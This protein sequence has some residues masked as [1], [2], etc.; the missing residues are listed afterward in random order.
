MKLLLILVLKSD[1]WRTKKIPLFV[2]I[3][4]GWVGHEQSTNLSLL[5]LS[6][7]RGVGSS[8]SKLVQVHYIFCFLRLPL[9]SVVKLLSSSIAKPQA[10]LLFRLA[11]LQLCLWDSIPSICFKLVLRVQPQHF[12]ALAVLVFHLYNFQTLFQN[13][14]VLNITFDLF[15]LLEMLALVF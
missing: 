3:T 5:T 14:Q 15:L 12:S 8:L 6:Q 7:L 2:T 10:L 11:R 1:T 9:S 13:L 4:A